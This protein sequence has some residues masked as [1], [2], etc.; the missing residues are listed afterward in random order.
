M[1]VRMSD[2]HYFAPFDLFA[3]R[4]N[5][6]E[7]LEMRYRK[8][9]LKA[10]ID[11]AVRIVGNG[12]STCVKVLKCVEGQFNKAF[13]LT[14]DNN[15]ELVVKIPNPNAGPAFYTT[16]S[17]VATRN[18]LRDV[19]G[20][21]VPRIYASSSDSENTVGAEYIFEEKSDGIPLGNFWYKL[22]QEA[23][24]EIIRQIVDIETKLSSLSFLKHGGIYFQSDL[25]SKGLTCEPLT[26]NLVNSSSRVLSH[27]VLE[28]FSIGPLTDVRLWEGEKAT[29]SLDRAHVSVVSTLSIINLA[30]TE[31]GSTAAE[32]ITAL[33]SNE[34]LWAKAHAKVRMNYHR[35]MEHPEI[36]EDYLSLLQRY[37]ALAPYLVPA[38]S[39][40]APKTL[41]HPDLH[42]DNIFVD[43]NTKKNNQY[44]RLAIDL[45][46]R[47]FLAECFS[48]NART[49]Q[50]RYF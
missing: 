29:M 11:E 22:P 50:S 5:E 31:P 2:T 44:H 34:I 27:S 40:D 18:F 42:L 13:I 30:K 16:A 33:G 32:Y 41:S 26:A 37:V 46:L 8:F 20:I 6:P 10:L 12:A 9:N 25:E 39:R 21:S 4:C 49:S 28:D 3:Q 19:L 14:M 45:C 47:A 1:A 15:T 38:A 43:P 48:T 36:P 17:E 24:L 7:K 35:S 23:Q